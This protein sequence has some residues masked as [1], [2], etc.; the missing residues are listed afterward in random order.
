LNALTELQQYVAKA[1]KEAN[2]A[3]STS[4]VNCALQN[5]GSLSD[6]TGTLAKSMVTVYQFA[7]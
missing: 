1:V 5:V 4:Q 3:H 6:Q 7:K 2:E